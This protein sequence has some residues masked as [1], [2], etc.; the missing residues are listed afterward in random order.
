M[1]GGL[2]WAAGASATEVPMHGVLVDGDGLARSGSAAATFT[3]TGTVE[4]APTTWSDT[5]TVALQDGAFA[6]NLGATSPIADALLAAEDLTVSVS[7]DGAASAPVP[8]GWA[9]RARFA[10]TA[11]TATTAVTATTAATAGHAATATALSTPYVGAGAISVSG[12]TIAW[13]NPLTASAGVSLT[14]TAFTA[15]AAWFDGRYVVNGGA[16]STQSAASIAAA[17]TK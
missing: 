17:G 10:A 8:V 9:P 16:L 13:T 5:L 14:G 11:A 3:L 6:V 1:L 4:G 15:D 12:P 2:L 7:V